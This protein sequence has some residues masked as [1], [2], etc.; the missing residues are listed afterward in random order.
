MI[1]LMHAGSGP[2]NKLNLTSC[3]GSRYGQGVVIY[4]M[5]IV[6]IFVKMT[7]EFHK[8]KKKILATLRLP[9]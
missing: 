5:F 6:W 7:H 9:L 4:Y 2:H 3:I 8:G 1:C